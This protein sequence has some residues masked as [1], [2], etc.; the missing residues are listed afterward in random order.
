MKIN[1]YTKLN[2]VGLEADAN[3]I[4]GCLPQYDVMIIDWMRP[5]KRSA[6]IAIH[7]E[8]VRK[9]LLHLAP[10]NIAVPNPEWWEPTFTPL[11]K[12]IDA[13]WCKT[14][15]TQEIFSTIHSNCIYTGFTSIDKYKEG[16]AKR[17]MFLHLAGKSSH[18]GT[19]AVV[20]VWKND[21]SLP[22]LYLQKIENIG[23]CHI[24]KPNVICEFRRVPDIRDIMNTS[25]FHLCCSKAEGFGHYINEALSAGAVVITTDAAPMNELVTNEY[26]FIVPAFVCGK[27]RL[28]NEYCVAR[29]DFKAT[30]RTAITTDA[31]TLLA[32]SAKARQAFIKR[33]AEFKNKINQLI[34]VHLH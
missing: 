29:N 25:L 2:G 6:D 28:S 13:V 19:E 23:K 26:G 7:L 16:V 21:L 22:L 33:D 11:L 14:K 5:V 30:I 31:N 1:I 8:H 27:H 3:I 20:D 10:Y 9:E 34:N 15:Y 32:M 12:R 18:K 4:K 17:I 24:N